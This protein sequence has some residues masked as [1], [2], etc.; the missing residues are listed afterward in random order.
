MIPGSAACV[1]AWENRSR[2]RSSAPPAGVGGELI[3]TGYIPI[4]AIAASIEAEL[5]DEEA[6]WAQPKK[7]NLPLRRARAASRGVIVAAVTPPRR[8][9][10]RSPWS[11]TVSTDVAAVAMT[12]GSAGAD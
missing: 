12:D 7:P 8:P 11:P 9:S 3:A 4:R 6:A 2:S 1:L 5:A 10:G